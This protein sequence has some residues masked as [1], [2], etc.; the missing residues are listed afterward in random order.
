MLRSP[1]Y[2]EIC[3]FLE[4]LS[5]KE[6]VALIEHEANEAYKEGARAKIAEIKQVLELA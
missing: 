2:T 3:D 6:I 5:T 4:D 1:K